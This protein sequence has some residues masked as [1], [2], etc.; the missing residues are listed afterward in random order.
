MN[1]AN[2]QSPLSGRLPST[3]LTSSCFTL[4]E[5]VVAIGVLALLM[6]GAYSGLCLI[7]SMQSHYLLEDKA[8]EVLDNAVERLA[9]EPAPDVS[10]A[11]EI[12][13]REFRY[14]G[15]ENDGNAVLECA[16]S[17]SNLEIR[18]RTRGGN[19]LAHLVLN[20]PAQAA[21]EGAR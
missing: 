12:L 17:E 2:T 6:T 7:S 9:A 8:L 10:R 16:A 5:V 21:A 15:L 3:A 20:L 14:S 19:R 18:I 4:I 13:H 11:A 1:R